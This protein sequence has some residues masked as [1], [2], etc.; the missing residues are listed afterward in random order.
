M[1]SF[2]GPLSDDAGGRFAINATTGAVTVANG[3]L[4]DF[5]TAASHTITMVAHDANGG[6]SGTQSFTI[7]LIDLDG[8]VIDGTVSGDVIDGSHDVPQ[9]AGGTGLATPEDDIIRGG[10]GP[11]V[12]SALGGDDLVVG[13]RGPDTLNGGPGNDTVSYASSDAG[14]KIKLNSPGVQHGGDA[15]G[16]HLSNFENIIGSKFADRL[17]GDDNANTISG[18]QGDDR[19]VG[20]ADK[21]TLL[22]GAGDD[23]LRGGVGDDHLTGGK[24]SDT[25]GFGTG[26]GADTVLDYRAGVDDID[27]KGTTITGYAQLQSHISDI[28]GG[29]VIDFGNGDTLTILN[30]TKDALNH[31]TADFH[32]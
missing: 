27:L 14:V 13:G 18:R 19:L 3:A 32:F 28:A 24:G 21:D 20:G 25:F 7:N 1:I 6:T 22:G 30:T 10:A 11:D 12:I 8:S 2:A 26:F 15:K 23:K 9:P 31:H 5:E 16:D 4:L 17:F 29:V